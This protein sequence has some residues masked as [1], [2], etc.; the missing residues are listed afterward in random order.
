MIS[1][2]M[3]RLPRPSKIAGTTLSLTLAAAIQSG[4][5]IADTPSPSP[6]NRPTLSSAPTSTY[7]APSLDGSAPAASAEAPT[8]SAAASASASALSVEA[9]APPCPQGMVHVGRFCIDAF[10][11]ALQTQANDG[12]WVAHPYFER[13]PK[14]AAIRA[15]STAG[16]FPQ[17]YIS[18]VESKTACEASGK[19]LCTKGEW[20][21]ACRGKNNSAFPYGGDRSQKDRCNSGKL[22]LLTQMFN[23]VPGGWKYDEHFNSPELNKTPGFLAKSGEYE[24]CT[25]DA[26]VHDMVGNL[27]EWVSDTVTDEFM[28]KLE[29]DPVERRYQPWHDG[30]GVFMG[31]FYSTTGEHGPGCWFITVAHEPTYHDYSTG[32]RC[33]E[34]AAAPPASTKSES[35]VTKP[36][37]S[38]AVHSSASSP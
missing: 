12:S 35:H 1:S 14:G 34:N 2:T 37:P 13:P 9:E 19:R 10:E 5:S 38:A 6:S 36:S 28:T 32:F 20:Q 3:T 25:N 23:G 15:V 11:D 4:C 27:H 31:G 24:G 8:S 30:N 33:C 26:G 7:S 16:Q 22:H 17:G 18:R 21:R 29:E